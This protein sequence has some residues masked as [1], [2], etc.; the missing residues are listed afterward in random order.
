M[1]QENEVEEEK[2]KS[3]LEIAMERISGLPELTPEEIAEQKEKEYRPVGEA[4]ANKYLQDIIDVQNIPTELCRHQGDSG[5]IVRRAFISYLC[6]SVQLEDSQMAVKALTGLCKLAEDTEGI[7]EQANAAWIRVQDDFQQLKDQ[8][9]QECEVSEKEKLNVLGIF[10]SAVR[11]N[12]T[13]NE[14][15]KKKLSE[16][17]RTFEPEMEKLRAMF[18]QKLQTE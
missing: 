10:G 11:P 9:L 6:R 1:D 4:L 15:L 16:L 14:S 5:R 2:V 17:Y 7:K 18:L 13:D 3:A 8:T 12:M